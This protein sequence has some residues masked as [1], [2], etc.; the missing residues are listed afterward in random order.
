MAFT[1]IFFINAG[2]YDIPE[3]KIMEVFSDK[4]ERRRYW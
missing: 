3:E 4:K 1:H 2:M